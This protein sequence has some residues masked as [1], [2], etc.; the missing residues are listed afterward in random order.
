MLLL[1][2]SL[3][4]FH[5]F[6]SFMRRPSA[7]PSSATGWSSTLPSSNPSTGHSQSRGLPPIHP[8][9]ASPPT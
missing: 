1:V 2:F 3:V 5:F 8:S 9:A 4:S 6:T 7:V